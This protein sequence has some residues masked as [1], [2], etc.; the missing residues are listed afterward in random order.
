MR[1][2]L[3]SLLPL[4]FLAG[5]AEK[6]YLLD[7]KISTKAALVSQ[8]MARY[9]LNESEARCVGE[10]LGNSLS[11]WQLRQLIAAGAGEHGEA[12]AA[13]L[14]VRDL[15]R[16]GSQVRDPEVTLEVAGA[17]S[18]CGVSVSKIVSA[19]PFAASPLETEM[20]PPAAPAPAEAQEGQTGA[21]SANADTARG[22]QNGPLNYQPSEELVSALTA[23]EREDYATAARLAKIAAD[24]K[25]SGAQQLL[26][27]LYSF[28]RG[29]PE[30]HKAAA[31]YYRLAAEQGWSEAM[32]N[33][34]RAYETGQGVPQDQ[35]EALK[36]YLLASTRTTEDNE[37]V[38]RNIQNIVHDMSTDQIEKAARLAHDWN[39]GR[40]R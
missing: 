19:T 13:R 20:T 26:G 24:R 23:Y 40:G 21:P 22:V 33:L 38:T 37:M 39:R 10:R 16:V 7:Y 29:V 12:G 11:I 25:D 2:L 34:G 17:T 28:G 14:T 15:L 5:C 8:D 27:G 36:W 1:L 31:E 35:V 9:G 30:D 3:L 6:A 32:N 18:G 4:G